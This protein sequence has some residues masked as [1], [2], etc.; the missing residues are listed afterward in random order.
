MSLIFHHVGLL[1]SQPELARRRLRLLGYSCGMP[2]YDP[3]QNVELCMCEGP[4]GAPRMEL[5]TPP[6]TN[7]SLSR[8][9][10]RKDDY[11]Y[12]IC[13]ATPSIANG[14]LTLNSSTL[15]SI[16]EVMPPKPAVLFGG[17]LV[18]FYSVPGMGLVELLEDSKEA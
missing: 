3:E 2:V 12:H 10:R 7:L 17:S 9:L 4:P 13:F 8:L 5:V 11:C 18:A 16:I 1:T 15:D 6:A 14:I